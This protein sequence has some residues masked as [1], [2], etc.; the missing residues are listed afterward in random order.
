MVVTALKAMKD[1]TRAAAMTAAQNLKS[2]SL[3][4]LVPGVVVHTTPE[5]LHAV[6]KL[7]PVVFQNAGWTLDGGPVALK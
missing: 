1:P 4:M 7:Q 6:S 3:D 5:D 2:T